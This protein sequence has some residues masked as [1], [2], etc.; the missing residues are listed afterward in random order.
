MGRK[1]YDNSFLIFEELQNNFVF[2]VKMARS[3]KKWAVL[4]INSTKGVEYVSWS[5][6]SN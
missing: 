2:M 5:F 4:Y 6:F 3:Q 1:L